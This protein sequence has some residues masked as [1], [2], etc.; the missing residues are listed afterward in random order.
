MEMA[1]FLWGMFETFCKNYISA[2][3][4]VTACGTLAQSF[5]SPIHGGCKRPI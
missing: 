1:P 4:F 3:K 2:F 5:I